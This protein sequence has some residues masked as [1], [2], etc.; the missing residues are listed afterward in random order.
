MILLTAVVAGI[1]AALARAY[2]GNRQLQPLSLRYEWLVVAAFIPQLIAFQLPLT[3][4]K[5]PDDGARIALVGSQ[6]LLIVFA[7]LNRKA[8]GFWALGIGLIL[9]FAV[10]VLNGGLMPI[11]PETVERLARGAG[12]WEVGERLGH[13]KDLILPVAQTYLSWLS[14][15]FTLP[16]WIPYRVAFSVGDII[17][18]FGAFWL[19]W[20][21]GGSQRQQEEEYP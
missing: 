3:R 5:F 8:K 15:R 17:I 18:G 1:V 9:N 12:S 21:L 13:T 10:I 2:W 4:A 6:A 7:W 11:S 20:S 16:D 14:D 19:L